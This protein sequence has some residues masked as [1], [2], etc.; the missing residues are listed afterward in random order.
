LLGGLEPAA[1]RVQTRENDDTMSQLFDAKLEGF[2]LSLFDGIASESSTGDKLSWLAIQRYVR[3]M[4]GGYVYLE[5][6]SHLGGSLQQHLVDPRCQRIV[7]IDPRPA[8]Q[9]DER[10]IDF[11]YQDNSTARMLENL[12]AVDPTALD[13]VHTLDYSSTTLPESERQIIREWRP[14]LC[15]I[16]GEH[17]TAAVMADFAFCREVSAADAVIL[18]H[19]SRWVAHALGEIIALLR[20]EGAR[21]EALMLGGSTFALALGESRALADPRVRS[22]EGVTAASSA[23]RRFRTELRIRQIAKR[24]VPRPIWVALRALRD[25]VMRR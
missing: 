20:R 25:G 12:R 24:T 4:P 18:F 19:D 17:T 9:P 2:D 3:R 14:N 13:K 1:A 15:F 16:D 21:F 22:I 7:S 10:G 5:I 8:V 23:L 6:G 11:V